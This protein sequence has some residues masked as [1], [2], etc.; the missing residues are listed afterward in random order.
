TV[1]ASIKNNE[2]IVTLKEPWDGDVVETSYVNLVWV[3]QDLEND[4]LNYR[5]YYSTD[6]AAVETRDPGEISP[7]TTTETLLRI[8]DLT[9]GT[10]Y[11]TVIPNDGQIDGICVSRVWHFTVAIKDG[12]DVDPNGDPNGDN[13]GS[14]GK[15][16]EDGNES[17]SDKSD[18]GAT[19]LSIGI[20]AIIVAL[21]LIFMVVSKRKKERYRVQ[22]AQKESA[23]L[24]G[25]GAEGAPATG[26]YAGGSDVMKVDAEK[27][28]KETDDAG[29]VELPE[30][31]DFALDRGYRP[32]VAA[33]PSEAA[34]AKKP[35]P[36][37]VPVPTPKPVAAAAVI[38]PE[39]PKIVP[40]ARSK[41]EVVK[42]YKKHLKLDAEQASSLYDSGYESFSQLKTITMDDLLTMKGL[43][44]KKAS[45]LKVAVV[46][47][48]SELFD[49]ESVPVA[50]ETPKPV[51]VAVSAKPKESVA[52]KKAVPG[53]TP[54]PTPVPVPTPAPTPVPTPTPMPVPM[55]VP[56]PVPV[57]VGEEA[58]TQIDKTCP[59]CGFPVDPDEKSCPICE[60]IIE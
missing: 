21:I 12:G 7:V 52:A 45:R 33:V 44:L 32:A 57:P 54:T 4:T 35:T 1:D 55:E 18:L 10:W 56:K 23:E 46:N 42:D 14:N 13:N 37:P 17:V 50:P 25:M 27:P 11:W 31:T 34:G 15:P 24:L 8:V 39:L 6:L 38:P 40:A 19:Y 47:L 5:V 3:G 2:P 26:P 30:E 53:A 20:V 43:D 16:A 59:S 22:K 28:Y 48:P 9:N 29:R 51:P 58:K 49:D 41:D 36:V 60:T